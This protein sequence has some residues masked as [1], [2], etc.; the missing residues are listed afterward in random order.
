[1]PTND[2]DISAQLSGAA[3]PGKS[4]LWRAPGNR[5]CSRGVPGHRGVR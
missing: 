1:L 4:S 2:A 3:G 5:A